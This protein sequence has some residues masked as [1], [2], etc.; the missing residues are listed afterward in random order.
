V[1]NYNLSKAFG[2]VTW[3]YEIDELINKF[4]DSLNELINRNDWSVETTDLLNDLLE[5]LKT[6]EDCIYC[7][8][9]TGIFNLDR[10]HKLINKIENSL[11][12]LEKEEQEEREK[13]DIINK[14]SNELFRT[15]NKLN[16]EML[17]ES[18]KEKKAPINTEIKK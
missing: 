15:N 1:L 5:T 2:K 12:E 13:K 8:Y 11:I 16:E 9:N 18:C 4:I 10:C 6:I 3:K 7:K 17:C 14:L